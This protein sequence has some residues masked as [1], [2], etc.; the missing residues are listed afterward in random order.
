LTGR[1]AIKDTCVV[2]LKEVQPK[3]VALLGSL[4][5]V[6]PTLDPID[7]ELFGI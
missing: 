3:V 6:L 4:Q 1:L 7:V 5:I 2:E